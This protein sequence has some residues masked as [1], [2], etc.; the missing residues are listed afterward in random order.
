MLGPGLWAS[1]IT[2][3][4]SV[5][6]VMPKPSLMRQKPPPEV[7]VMALTPAKEAPATML[8]AAIS[9]SACITIIPYSLSSGAM[10]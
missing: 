9:L 6:P 10:K 5:I 4:V 1:I 7:A 2:A 3:G 8:M